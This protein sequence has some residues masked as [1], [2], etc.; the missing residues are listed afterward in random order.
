MSQEKEFKTRKF[1]LTL[2][3]NDYETPDATDEQA[4]NHFHK[5]VVEMIGQYNLAFDKLRTNIEWRE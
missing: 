2:E 4:A 5:F 1:V 3:F